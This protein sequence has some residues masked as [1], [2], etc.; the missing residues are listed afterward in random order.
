MKEYELV[1]YRYGL[2]PHVYTGF[3]LTPALKKP[4]VRIIAG[5]EFVFINEGLSSSRGVHFQRVETAKAYADRA[6]ILVRNAD[7]SYLD[8]TKQFPA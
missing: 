6:G 2:K 5:K 3:C 4:K 8:G 7:W 1:K